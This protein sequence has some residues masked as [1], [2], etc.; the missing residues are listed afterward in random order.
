MRSGMA[1]DLDDQGPRFRVAIV[2]VL[3]RYE[4]LHV[5]TTN[6]DAC[7]GGGIAG[8]T[9]A[10]ALGKSQDPGS[11]IRID[12]YEAGSE[13]TTVGAGISV[14]A[15]TWTIMRALGIYDDLASSAIGHSDEKREE[16]HN[17]FGK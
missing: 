16:G 2:C 6:L 13:I 3:R 11:T 15:R 14:W 9:L 1:Q 4:A 10:V 5:C 17:D 8:L 12:M 7:R